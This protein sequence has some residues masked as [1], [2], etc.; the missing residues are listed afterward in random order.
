MSYLVDT[1]VIS[2][3]MK[4]L[5]SPVVV[6]WLAE[7]DVER[8]FLSVISL[9]E[10]RRGIV[11]LEPGQRRDRLQV[12]YRTDLPQW[13]EHRLLGIDRVVAERWGDLMARTRKRGI[14]LNAMDGFLAATAE[15]HRLTLVTRNIRDFDALG[16][17][18]LNPWDA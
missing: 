14:A 10:I 3:L 15:A 16:L 11:Q 7:A 6:G 12:W 2:E 5:P 13:A 9:A 17:T 4:P 18:L 1:N 8:L